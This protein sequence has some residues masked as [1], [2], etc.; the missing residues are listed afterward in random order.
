MSTIP[1][2]PEALPAQVVAIVQTSNGVQ[3]ALIDTVAYAGLAPRGYRFTGVWRNGETPT[4]VQVF[5]LQADLAKLGEGL[6]GTQWELNPAD[7]ATLEGLRVQMQAVSAALGSKRLKAVDSFT[8]YVVQGVRLESLNFGQYN[9]EVLL[10]FVGQAKSESAE[11][12]APRYNVRQNMLYKLDALQATVAD[13]AALAAHLERQ[14]LDGTWVLVAPDSLPVETV[15]ANPAWFKPPFS[16]AASQED[17]SLGFNLYWRGERVLEVW[18]EY[19]GLYALALDV[20]PESEPPI[21]AAGELLYSNK[22]LSVA[23]WHNSPVYRKKA[24]QVVRELQAASAKHL[25][26]MDDINAQVE[27]FRAQ[28]LE[29]YAADIANHEALVLESQTVE[30]NMK[31]AWLKLWEHDG[32]PEGGKNSDDAVLQVR[33]IEGIE[34]VSEALAIEAL[35]KAKPSL[36]KISIDKTGLKKDITKGSLALPTG[37]IRADTTT[38]AWYIETLL[39]KY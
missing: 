37:V 27:A 14:L 33:V 23:A 7:D 2:S 22:A 32:K 29:P 10:A 1:Y 24:A 31:A 9:G 34:I 12:D 5:L 30:A 18:R 11:E 25:K 13:S 38:C 6:R 21:V 4:P 16:P 28:L 17:E 20:T 8:P 3:G 35:Q 39:E 15:Q 19:D 36:L 26:L